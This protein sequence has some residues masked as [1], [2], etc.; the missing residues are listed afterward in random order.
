ME[1]TYNYIFMFPLGT[2][3]DVLLVV[4][5]KNMLLH[6]RIG[7]DC[8]VGLCDYSGYRRQFGGECLNPTK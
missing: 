5:I 6:Y 2:F 1:G 3:G 4:W 8:V 7:I